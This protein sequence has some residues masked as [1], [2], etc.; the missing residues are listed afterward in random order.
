[1]GGEMQV[2]YEDNQIIVVIKPHNMPSQ[3]D[4][5]ND[6]DLL[7]LVKKYV[8]EKYNKQGNVFIGLV[9]RLDRP[10]G[11]LMVFAR[12]SKSAAR[13]SK[14][15]QDGEFK[16]VYYC[17]VEGR[18]KYNSQRLE[19]FLKKDEKRNIVAIA[20]RL[21]EGTKRAELIYKC[22]EKSDKRSLL[23]VEILT[24]R[25]HQIRV[26]LANI[27]YP[28]FGDKKYG[29]SVQKGNLALWAG[30]LEFAHPVT[31]QKMKFV[32]EPDISATPWNEFNVE[33]YFLR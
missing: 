31:K 25:S 33:K 20:P 7:S 30:R 26:Q 2:V 4:A 8:K 14:Q 10:T 5:S 24:G 27:G 1:M 19:N 3:E 11:G 21:E 18:I 23:E 22:L 16:K 17:V 6:E 12:N 15:M 32:A 28:L 29:K 9:H 13:L